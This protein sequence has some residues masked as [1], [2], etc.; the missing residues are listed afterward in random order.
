M[1]NGRD[2]GPE[3]GTWDVSG[4]MEAACGGLWAYDLDRKDFLC[5]PGL[6]ELTACG[7][8]PRTCRSPFCRHLLHPD[9]L[10]ELDQA[11]EA[12]SAGASMRLELAVRLRRPDGGWR[13]LLLRGATLAEDDTS[14]RMEGLAVTTTDEPEL[15]EEWNL[16]ASVFEHA[17]TAMLLIDPDSGRIEEANAMAC[18]FYGYPCEILRTMTILDINALPPEKVRREMEAAR[19]TR[20]TFFH[21]RHRL[22]SGE[23]R[24][25]EVH[26]G[27]VRVHGRNLLC[28]IIHDATD[29]LRAEEALRRSEAFMSGLFRAAPWA[30][31]PCASA[32]SARSTTCSAACSATRP[33][34]CAAKA[35]ASSTQAPRNFCASGSCAPRWWS[36]SA[37]ARWETVFRRKDGTPL[38]VLLGSAWMDPE[39][40]EEGMIFTVLDITER[41][42]AEQELS[43]VRRAMHQLADA[44]PSALFV[45]DARGRIT[46][47]NGAAQALCAGAHVVGLPFAQA[48]PGF[49]GLDDM[50]RTLREGGAPLSRKA[51][52]REMD[53]GLRYWD[54]LIYP[55]DPQA[56]RPDKRHGRDGRRRGNRRGRHRAG[57]GAPGRGHRAGA[58]GG[59][60]DPERKM[61]SGRRAGGGHGP[62]DQ[63]PPGGH[64][65][66]RPEHPP[67]ARPRP[68]RQP[69]SRPGP[70]LPHGRHGR[71]HGRARHP[72]LPHGHHRFRQPRGGHREQHAQFRP[73]RPG[74]PRPA[75]PEPVPARRCNWWRAATTSPGATTSGASRSS[76]NWTRTC[77]GFPARPRNCNRSSSTC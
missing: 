75:G 34:N 62:R 32:S 13:P 70:R 66:G 57:R 60:P 21:F 54:L 48:L 11:L 72:A 76:P 55:L 22:A 17:Q 19:R 45:V 41:K 3:T 31:A 65:S 42:H 25:V 5:G 16:F 14:R 36:A 52:P 2:T 47:C 37:A 28:S 63:Q 30:W 61:M 27:P 49:P 58:H 7:A 53:G 74:R 73:R 12:C 1:E 39:R 38:N 43:R 67:Q 51:M 10:P 68:A 23:L 35:R 46:L 20:R 8:T 29:R 26:S 77:P 64:P 9:D 56:P 44:M 50:L 15:P 40:P 6:P 71:L 4:V 33:T 59:N 18:R 69:R 24:D